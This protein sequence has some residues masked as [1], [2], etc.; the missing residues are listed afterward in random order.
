MSERSVQSRI[1]PTEAV[2]Q[3]NLGNFHHVSPTGEI[4]RTGLPK[5]RWQSQSTSDSRG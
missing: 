2:L 3:D 1:L 4:S 5:V